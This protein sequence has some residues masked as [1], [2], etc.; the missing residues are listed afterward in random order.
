MHRTPSTQPGRLSRAQRAACVPLGACLGADL[1]CDEHADCPDGSDELQ[2]I[3]LVYWP[4]YL[5]LVGIIVAIG[6][7]LVAVLLFR[8]YYQTR[9]YHVK[10]KYKFP[11]SETKAKFSSSV[12]V[13]LSKAYD[14][15]GPGS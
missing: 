13:S 7:S 5:G 14:K 8:R 2:C 15:S 11:R 4:L 9:R 12:T 1:W 10:R 3:R 6:G